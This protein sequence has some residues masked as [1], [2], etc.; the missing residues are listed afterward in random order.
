M[1]WYTRTPARNPTIIAT[2]PV[3]VAVIPTTAPVLRE[4]TAS[5][6]EKNGKPLRSVGHMHVSNVD[7][8]GNEVNN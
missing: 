8:K 3:T 5:V 7:D 2:M 1:Q 4:P 6:R